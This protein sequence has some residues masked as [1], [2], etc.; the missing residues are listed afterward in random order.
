MTWI[1]QTTISHLAQRDSSSV[2]GRFN[3]AGTP[4][5]RLNSWIE[6]EKIELYIILRGRNRFLQ[7]FALRSPSKPTRML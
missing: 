3:K 5:G 2:V 7:G 6:P 4:A 1:I